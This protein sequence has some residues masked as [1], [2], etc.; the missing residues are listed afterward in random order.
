MMKLAFDPACTVTVPEG[1]ISP[2]GPAMA[3]ILYVFTGTGSNAA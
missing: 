3:V 1:L 2:F